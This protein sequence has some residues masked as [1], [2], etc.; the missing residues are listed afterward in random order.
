MVAN[1]LHNSQLCLQFLD[2]SYHRSGIYPHLWQSNPDLWMLERWFAIFFSQNI[3][4]TWGCLSERFSALVSSGP[5]PQMHLKTKN[6]RITT[7]IEV[8]LIDWISGQ[9]IWDRSRHFVNELKTCFSC[10]AF[11]TTSW[12]QLTNCICNRYIYSH[13]IKEIT[14][15][16]IY[17][18]KMYIK[19]WVASL[20]SPITKYKINKWNLS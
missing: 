7:I 16:L 9:A 8:Q 3:Q 5:S 12:T 14:S 4:M 1:T 2:L 17:L 13:W 11:A 10:A 19:Y 20:T 6:S 15:I 18:V